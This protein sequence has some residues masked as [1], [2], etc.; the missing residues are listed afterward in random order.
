MTVVVVH[1]VHP[2]MAKTLTLANMLAAFQAIEVEFDM[3]NIPYR[4][5]F[6]QGKLKES[7]EFAKLWNID[8]RL[9]TLG[10][11]RR[12]SRFEWVIKSL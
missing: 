9:E 5:V 2:K 1:K 4:V 10:H 8:Y 6:H 3:A 12:N 7:K 11:R